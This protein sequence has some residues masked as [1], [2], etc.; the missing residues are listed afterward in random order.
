MAHTFLTTTYATLFFFSSVLSHPVALAHFAKG[1]QNNILASNL[2]KGEAR[3][4][5]K[6][7]A[8]TLT[9][10]YTTH[11]WNLLG[12]EHHPQTAAEQTRLQAALNLLEQ[13]HILWIFNTQADCHAHTFSIQSGL[14]LTLNQGMAHKGTDTS[15]QQDK[16]FSSR[17]LFK[18]TKPEA[19]QEMDIL[20]FDHFPITKKVDLQLY[21]N[22]LH[23]RQKITAQQRPIP[24][25]T[26]P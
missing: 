16:H 1:L 6:Q 22:T 12:F 2:S 7:V 11:H 10:E 23:S 4:I 18:C 19:L 13:P 5:V 20:I 26:L 15:T 24:L 21:L 9:L 17:Y 14:L 8:D 3:I 25:T